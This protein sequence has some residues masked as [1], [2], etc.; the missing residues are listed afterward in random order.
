M[1]PLDTSWTLLLNKALYHLVFGALY[2][3]EEQNSRACSEKKMWIWLTIYRYIPEIWPNLSSLCTS[4]LES[5][6]RCIG[7][8]KAF[9]ALRQAMGASARERECSIHTTVLLCW[10]QQSVL[11]FSI[12]IALSFSSVL[13]IAAPLHPGAR[14]LLAAQMVQRRCPFSCTYS[15]QKYNMAL[16]QDKVCFCVNHFPIFGM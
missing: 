13:S 5:R 15:V 9:Q 12:S 2:F 16:L 3:R 8:A 7:D 4:S 11:P 14:T 6:S 1:N 10:R